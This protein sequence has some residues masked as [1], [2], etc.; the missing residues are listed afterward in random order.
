MTDKT[1]DSYVNRMERAVKLA[2]DKIVELQAEN[3]T[4]K[5]KLNAI[6]EEK[7]ILADK[8]EILQQKLR[9]HSVDQSNHQSMIIH[10]RVYYFRIISA[11]WL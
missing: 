1:S 2:H 7:M 11:A 8:L 4:L 10:L 3:K 5:N 6:V 9:L